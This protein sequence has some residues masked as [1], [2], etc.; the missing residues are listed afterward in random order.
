MLTH[1]EAR[2]FYDRFGER[3]D[4][5]GWYED[6]P[7]RRLVRLADFS[8]ARK[9]LEF[10]CGTGRFARTLLEDHLPSDALYL[11]L[12]IS[13]TMLKIAGPR[14]QQFAPRAALILT[15]GAVRLA[16]RDRSVDRIVATY[17]LDLLSEPDISLFV[18]ESRRVLQPGG[19]LCLANL[20]LGPTWPTWL[21]SLL[22]RG[23]HRLAPRLVGGCRPLD[24]RPFLPSADWG[25]LAMQTVVSGGLASQVLVA[26]SL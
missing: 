1:Q 23:I 16:C 26:E 5:Q 6:E 20:T 19:R 12:D 10:G 7:C 17:V 25:I 24:A 22:W 4:R 3:Q 11:G 14:L 9:V 2:E 13:R 18:D 21:A 8:T 15:G